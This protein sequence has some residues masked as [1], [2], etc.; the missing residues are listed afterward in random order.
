MRGGLG[1]LG[2]LG[3]WGQGGDLEGSL[4][5]K[6]VRAGMGGV[7]TRKTVSL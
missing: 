6:V 5:K 7:G 3:W 2:I 1:F 4:P